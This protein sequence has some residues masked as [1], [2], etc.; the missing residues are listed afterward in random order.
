MHTMATCHS[1]AGCPFDRGIDLHAD[2]PEPM[3]ID[4]ESTHSSNATAAVGGPEAEGDPED[5]V[6][7]NHIKLMTLMRDI[8]DLHQWVDAGGQPAENWTA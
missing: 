4:S 5:S 7:S 2:N 3:D 1:G 6:Y 8:N